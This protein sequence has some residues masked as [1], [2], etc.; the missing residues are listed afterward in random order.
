MLTTICLTHSHFYLQAAG[1]YTTVDIARLDLEAAARFISQNRTLIKAKQT[2]ETPFYCSHKPTSRNAKMKVCMKCGD[3]KNLHSPYQNM[4]LKISRKTWP[5]TTSRPHN[6]ASDAPALFQMAAE[7]LAANEKLLPPLNA[8]DVLPT[9]SSYLD[10]WQMADEGSG[11]DGGSD[12]EQTDCDSDAG[13]HVPTN[14]AGT[15]TPGLGVTQTEHVT[16]KDEDG[17]HNTNLDS[18]SL[19]SAAR[20]ASAVSLKQTSFVDPDP[21]LRQAAAIV[22]LPT[23]EYVPTAASLALIQQRANN[24]QR[25]RLLHDQQMEAIAAAAA[26]DLWQLQALELEEAR[27]RLAVVQ[28]LLSAEALAETQRLHELE[29]ALAF[30]ALAFSDG[31]TVMD[32]DAEAAGSAADVSRD[33][34]SAADVTSDSKMMATDGSTTAQRP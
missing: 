6:L 17:F 7:V 12:S 27:V 22:R 26:E 20:P 23:I 15:Q 9:T 25:L 10:I 24:E 19:C 2:M 28:A 34:S 4:S 16:V 14:M 31:D 32:M 18:A 21:L 11:S 13:D 1:T 3:G 5:Q 8:P 30:S 33:V 29:L